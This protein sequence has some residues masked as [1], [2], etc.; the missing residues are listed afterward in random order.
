[1]KLIVAGSRTITLQIGYLEDLM[2]FNDIHP[3]DITEF[4]SGTAEGMDKVGEKLAYSWGK[5][6]KKFPADWSKYRAAAGPI[7]NKQMAEYADALFL[8]W[9]GK[10]K[11]SA[12]MKE[13]MLKLNKPIYEV[14]LKTYKPQGEDND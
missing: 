7:R 9:D 4:V 10:S 5:S 1:M 8:V 13:E 11:G 14:I 3:L 12:N 2:L 6:V